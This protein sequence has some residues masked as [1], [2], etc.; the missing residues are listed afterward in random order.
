M[1]AI[2]LVLCFLA[3]GGA[4]GAIREVDFD[5]RIG[6]AV[7]LNLVF[8]EQ[9]KAVRLDR[10]FGA[11]P[12]VLELGYFGCLNLCSTTV[13]GA[14]EALS[15]TGLAA[16]KDYRAIFVSIDPRDER[17]VAERREGWHVLTGAASARALAERVG[18]RYAYEES[19]GEFA[20]PAGF[21]VLTPEGKVA[22]YFGGVRFD[23]GALRKALLAA[24][25]GKTT[26]LLDRVLLVC[27]HDPVRG[28]YS[29]GILDALRLGAAAFLATLGFF[30]WRRL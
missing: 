13:I 17:A 2:L 5:A 15:R 23:P 16:G 8:H 9:G 19:S 21:V 6:A 24:H 4:S 30:A 22:Q 25:A 14:T 3:A 26:T 7:P 10:F 29:E 28:R 12:V 11:A 20:H 18:F 27:F 1:K